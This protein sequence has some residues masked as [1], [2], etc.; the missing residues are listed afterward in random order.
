MVQGIE[1]V[2]EGEDRLLL[3]RLLSRPGLPADEVDG[4][5]TMFGKYGILEQARTEVERYCTEALNDLE[6]LPD[7]EARDMLKWFAGMLMRREN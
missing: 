2:T 5:R 3:E 7:S 4:V 6:T 1:R